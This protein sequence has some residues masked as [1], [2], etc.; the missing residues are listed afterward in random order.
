MRETVADFRP[1]L[2][3]RIRHLIGPWLT[4]VARLVGQPEFKLHRSGYAGTV[5][6]P[7]DEL[8]RELTRGGFAWGPVSWYHQPAVGSDPD[9]SWTFRRAP[10]SD[11]QLHVIL[12]ARAPDRI[13][14]YA[15]WE[16]SWLRHP[17]K[18]ARQLGIDRE[19]GSATMRKWLDRRDVDY[20]SNSRTR[21]KVGRAVR[22]VAAPL[23]GRVT[24]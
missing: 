10:L 18:H 7:R 17:I 3:Y 13:D 15:H 4:G 1:D 21:R 8:E 5:E 23:L 11:R 20:E 19:A 12:I 2:P 22:R 24:P 6:L 14:V 16:Y 9:G